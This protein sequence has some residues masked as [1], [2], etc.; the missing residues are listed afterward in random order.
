MDELFQSIVIQLQPAECSLCMSNADELAVFAQNFSK[1]G[2]SESV[3]W[4][5]E[6][7]V[8]SR[9]GEAGWFAA[10]G[11]ERRYVS[12][13]LLDQKSVDAFAFAVTTGRTCT[14]TELGFLFEGEWSGRWKA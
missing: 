5:V 6:P 2:L 4:D 8:V 12:R 3:I 9:P 7:P 11:E 13:V 1:G 10:V 14:P